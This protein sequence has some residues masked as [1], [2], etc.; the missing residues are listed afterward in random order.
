MLGCFKNG[1]REC[2]RKLLRLDGAFMRGQYIGQML[3]AVGV[4]ANNGIYPIA[5]G[6]VESKNQYSWSWFL[7]CLGDDFDL[8]SNS[9]F[10]LITDRQNGLLPALAKLFPSA[11]HRIVIIQKVIQKCDG[12]LNPAVAK[13]FDKIKAT[14]T[15]CT[16]EWNGFELY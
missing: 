2:G 7:K 13:L 4:D 11:E 15:G 6:I 8:Y 12:P 5:Y 14:S 16:M 3:T 1:F 9:N 10:T